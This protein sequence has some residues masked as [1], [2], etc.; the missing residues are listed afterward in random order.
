MANNLIDYSKGT[1]NTNNYGI[2]Q[3]DKTTG[4]NS[5][6]KDK[7]IFNGDDKN[8]ANQNGFS[9]LDKDWAAIRFMVPDSALEEID[10][11]NRYWSSAYDKFTDTSMGGNIGVNVRP[12]FTPYCDIHIPGRRSTT[13]SVT[14]ND[15]KGNFGMGRYYS[16]AIDDNEQTIFFE[17]GVPKFNSMFDFFT[18]AV[19]YRDSV[20]ANTGR[21][22]YG[23]EAGKLVGNVVMLAA[24]PLITIAIWGLKTAVHLIAG[25][26][27]FD[28]YYLEPT[29]HTYWA[30]V[31][32]LV[33]QLS[34]EIGILVPELMDKDT[35]ANKIGANIKL[36]RTDMKD[37]Q[38][39]LPG[40]IGDDNYID[41]FAIATKAQ[42]MA[43]TQMIKD[44]ERYKDDKSTASD[45][46]G[47]V[48]TKKTI[49]E[50]DAAGSTV[51]DTLNTSVMFS[52]YLE[53]TVKK[54]DS[55]YNDADPETKPTSKEKIAGDPVANNKKKL[56][57]EYFQKQPDG[58]YNTDKETTNSLKKFATALDSTVRDG[59]LHAVFRV[60]YTG[61]VTESFQNNIGEIEANGKM[62]SLAK[63]ARD[64]KF[65]MSG[66]NVVGDVVKEAGGVIKDVV[67]GGLDSVTYGLTNVIQTMTG[68]GYIDIPKKWD[69]SSISL[70]QITYT[71]KLISPYGNPYSRLQNIYIPLCM[72]LAGTLPLSTGK[73][74]YTS[75]FLCSLTSRG[76]QTIKKGMI[77][78]LTVTRG[79][80]NLGF[81]QNRNA[82]AID[83]SFTVTDFSNIMA[84]PV[85][86]SI[87]DT[88]FNTP[89]DDT[90]PISN[91]LSVVGSRSLLANKYLMPKV[92]LRYSRWKMAVDQ[93]ISP[94][95]MGMR[96]GESLNG[97][98]GGL[99][100]QR[101]LTRS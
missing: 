36:N 2:T 95:S 65:S 77:T 34:T 82:L 71:A 9:V 85:N 26:Q 80:S 15:R 60:E 51:A 76:L 48:K 87:F 78:S 56:N 73:S 94:S 7:P 42:A 98:L 23:Y 39:L 86:S 93:A 84:A 52:K 69:D 5:L 33:T 61:S 37:L 89:F 92:K 21:K 47:Y 63:G 101:T 6:S 59:S 50:K 31:N 70:P 27:A 12:Q 96:V 100:S 67:M 16:E 62:K 38:K 66:G 46:V 14:V 57:K 54:K 79:T 32:T 45:F 83:V 75:P 97:I 11:N 44:Y 55:Y 49:L 64:L 13:T 72:L 28:Y 19:D 4:L 68:G 53:K 10:A 88:V 90:S 3:N 81:D 43:N 99:V 20:L 25:N 58:T 22:P 17:F 30:T 8:I 74:S 91:Y 18:R 29:M 1:Y 40:I 24:F 41:V 35:Y